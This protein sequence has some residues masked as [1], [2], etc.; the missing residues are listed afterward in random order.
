[1]TCRAFDRGCCANDGAYDED[2]KL[3]YEAPDMPPMSPA[4]PPVYQVLESIR[5]DGF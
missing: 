2:E 5:R 1:M 4:P 3:L